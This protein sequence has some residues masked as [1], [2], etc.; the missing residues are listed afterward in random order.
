M[1]H[2]TP[3]RLTH[4]DS[5][6]SWTMSERNGR[7]HV[8]SQTAPSKRASAQNTPEI[9]VDGGLAWQETAVITL[10]FVCKMKVC[11]QEMYDVPNETKKVVSLGKVYT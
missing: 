7:D 1:P 6:G 11:T 2:I 8:D 9:R 10:K 4:G 5:V 3:P